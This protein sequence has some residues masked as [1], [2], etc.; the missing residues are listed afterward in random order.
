MMGPGPVSP[1]ALKNA[2]PFISTHVILFDDKSGIPAGPAVAW[3]LACC[4]IAP[5]QT[6]A[7]RQTNT[8]EF[9]FRRFI[10]IFLPFS[11]VAAVRPT[12]R[13]V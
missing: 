3:A 12:A 7:A 13:T 9:E 4:Q 10:R 8:S 2:V 1:G 6:I 5:V 11:V